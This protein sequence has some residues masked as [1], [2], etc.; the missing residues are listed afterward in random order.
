[1][2]VKV[3][4]LSKPKIIKKVKVKV[5]VA[6]GTKEKELSGIYISKFKTDLVLTKYAETINRVLNETKAS[7]RSGNKS[8]MTPRGRNE[9]HIATRGKHQEEV[10]D[11]AREIAKALGLNANLAELIGKHHD[12]G[13]TFNG[14]TGERI[15]SS[16]GQMLNCG[17]TVHNALSVDMLLSEGILDKIENAI[18][19]QHPE[20][21]QEELNKVKEEMYYVFDGILSHDGEGTKTK[22]NPNFDKTFKD[23]IDEKNKCYTTKEHKKSVL[24]M[25]MEGAIIRFADIIAYTRTDI[26]DGFQMGLLKG[27]DEESLINVEKENKKES[28]EESKEKEPDYQAYL[29]VIGTMVAYR[30]KLLSE[31]NQHGLIDEKQKLLAIQSN[32]KRQIDEKEAILKKIENGEKVETTEI[33][34]EIS[35]NLENLEKTYEIA[36]QKYAECEQKIIERARK[37]LNSIPE[38]NKKETVVEMMKNVFIKDLKE[39]SKDKNYIGF[40]PAIGEALF[41]LRAA[42]MDFIVKYTRR[43]FETEK[44]PSATLKLV[45]R[46]AQTLIDTGVIREYAIPDR[47]KEKIGEVDEANKEKTIKLLKESSNTSKDKLKF[48]RKVFHRCDNFL[49]P[50]NYTRTVDELELCFNPVERADLERRKL[51]YLEMQRR[52]KEIISNAIDSIQNIAEED[53]RIVLG[54]VQYK[55]ELKKEYARKI[56]DIR[57]FIQEQYPELTLKSGKKT[58]ISDETRRDII[59]KIVEK[60]SSDLERICAY[61]F[62]KEYVE[63][64]SDDTI[65]DALE[66]EGIITH[67]EANSARKRNTKK[68]VADRAA[69]AQGEV[70]KKAKE[71][72]ER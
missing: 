72:G 41:D 64:M 12:D 58:N 52:G 70:W 65:I 27:F 57:N 66:I 37:Y 40:S 14:H 48:R 15:M 18:K 9:A 33:A 62:A 13:H 17:Y 6:K 56:A 42:N 63:G 51:G 20:I 1:M 23:V 24:P 34:D 4:D 21:T 50:A 35:A 45:E 43:T 69:E 16:I 2:K 60:R 3:R 38:K 28:K 39:F 5:K 31:N 36:K 30:D 22:I 46:F 25:T 8:M 53:L 49:N 67:R 26:L 19:I 54:E 32:L 61:A 11:V 71:Q 68:K 44:L 55:G 47:Y 7:L 29:K 59:K 10:A